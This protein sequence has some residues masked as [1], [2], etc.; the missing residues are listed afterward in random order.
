MEV[1]MSGLKSE[2]K[3]KY[4]VECFVFLFVFFFFT[5]NEYMVYKVYN[6][7]CAIKS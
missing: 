6:V 5:E 2:M 3:C 1:C 7:F 4:V